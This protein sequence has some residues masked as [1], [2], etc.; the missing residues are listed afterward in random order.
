MRVGPHD[1][2]LEDENAR[3]SEKEEIEYE[4]ADE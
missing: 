4:E 3:P 1:E 2:E